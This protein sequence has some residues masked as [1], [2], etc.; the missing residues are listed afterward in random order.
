LV[1]Q[2]DA[3]GLRNG[4][5]FA[6]RP[7]L[8]MA[9]GSGGWDLL[10]LYF[11]GEQSNQGAAVDRRKKGFKTM[12][13]FVPTGWWDTDTLKSVPCHYLTQIEVAGGAGF[14]FRF[15]FNP[16]EL[17]DF[18]LGWATLDLFR[19]DVARGAASTP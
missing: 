16:G 2:K 17:F 10:A 18:L 13:M 7:S 1:Y 5:G 6:S 4:T 19:D 14:G 9:E 15:A 8:K 3:V 12:V 11:G